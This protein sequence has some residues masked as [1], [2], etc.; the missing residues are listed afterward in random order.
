[1]FI[2]LHQWAFTSITFFPG[3]LAA[4]SFSPSSFSLVIVA[5]L[6]SRHLLMKFC[7]RKADAVLGNKSCS[8]GSI[9]VRADTDWICAAG[10][11]CPQLPHT[12][13][14]GQGSPGWRRSS[15]SWSS[16]QPAGPSSTAHLCSA[17]CNPA[18]SASHADE[19]LSLPN[20]QQEK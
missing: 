2:C 6:D 17:A 13:S 4:I 11:S 3:W 20:R 5:S 16:L 19:H 15:H 10:V 9:S 14:G 12:A 8:L 1:M 18:S 7:R